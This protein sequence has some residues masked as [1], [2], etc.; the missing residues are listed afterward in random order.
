MLRV[1]RQEMQKEGP[2]QRLMQMSVMGNGGGAEG[3]ARDGS[4]EPSAWHS[5]GILTMPGDRFH[6]R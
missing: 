2:R 4:E 3:G 6:L 5:F 1:T